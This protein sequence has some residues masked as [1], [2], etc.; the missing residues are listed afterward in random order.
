MKGDRETGA[1]PLPS[2]SDD[3]MNCCISHLTPVSSQISHACYLQ[4]LPA[5]SLEERPSANPPRA[6]AIHKRV[7]QPPEPRKSCPAWITTLSP[8]LRPSIAC[9]AGSSG[10]SR[11]G[12]RTTSKG[13]RNT[14]LVSAILEMKSEPL[15][16]EF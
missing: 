15:N 12:T 1:P 7:P 3:F 9:P 6:P 5:E 2:H 4:I 16:P 8:S 10:A 13:W 14:Q 11:R